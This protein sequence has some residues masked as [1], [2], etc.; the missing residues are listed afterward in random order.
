MSGL[1]TTQP[2]IIPTEKID[3]LL[4]DEA[5]VEQLTKTETPENVMDLF[6][7]KGVNLSLEQVQKLIERGKKIN[8]EIADADLEKV[9]GGVGIKSMWKSV[10]KHPYVTL[11]T[12]LGTLAIAGICGVAY[13]K[14]HG[15]EMPTKE[16][17]ATE[18][19]EFPS[20]SQDTNL[21]PDIPYLLTPSGRD[22]M[23]NIHNGLKS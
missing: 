15:T 10:K 4:K 16:E 21:T 12:T 3:E 19:K 13:N 5:F 7:T 11:A 8:E 23:N 1:E 9:G 2:E 20:S 22:A 6:K 14:S 17:D 18:M